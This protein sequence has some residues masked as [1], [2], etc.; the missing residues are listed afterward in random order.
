[1]FFLTDLAFEN[2]VK[3]EVASENNTYDYNLL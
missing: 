1:M 2:A 3:P